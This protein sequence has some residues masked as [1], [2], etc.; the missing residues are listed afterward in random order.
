MDRGF[1]ESSAYERGPGAFN[2]YVRHYTR[3]G[4]IAAERR[5]G[6]AG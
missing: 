5:L 6:D 3:N 2:L 1:M 4:A